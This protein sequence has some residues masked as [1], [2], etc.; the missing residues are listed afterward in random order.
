MAHPSGWFAQGILEPGPRE[1]G[2]RG[3][4]NHL[5]GLESSKWMIDHFNRQMVT[6]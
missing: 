4:E 3:F 1:Q 6:H 2:R 5:E